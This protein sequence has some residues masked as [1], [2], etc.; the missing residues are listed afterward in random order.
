VVRRGLGVIVVVALASVFGMAGT[1]LAQETS[2]T[3]N[4]E[5]AAPLANELVT[6]TTAGSTIQTS[7]LYLYYE[8][9]GA[10]CATSQGEQFNRK[11]AHTFDILYPSS[12]SFNYTSTFK[13]V[14]AGTYRICAYLYLD[15]DNPGSQAP[16]TLVTTTIEVAIKPGTD[17]DG[18]KIPDSVD[19]CKSIPSTEESGCP[20]FVAPT[21]SVAKQKA[22]KGAYTFSVT[23]NQ[24]CDITYT[25]KVGGIKLQPGSASTVDAKAKRLTIRLTKVNL[26]KLKKLLQKRSSISAT[27]TV[28]ALDTPSGSST[29]GDPP[30]PLVT[31]R[32]FTITR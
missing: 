19:S 22:G 9:N 32:N 21:V 23:C 7:P 2:L 16:R 11:N 6:V 30:P 12:G 26:A 27:L 29:G 31:K 13:P 18:D 15:T 25:A 1:A 14:Q 20:I 4:V 10:G 17:L 3:M 28:S 8:L 24:P 5:T